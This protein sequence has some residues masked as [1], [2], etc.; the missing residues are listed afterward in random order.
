MNNNITLKS[1][2]DRLIYKPNIQIHALQARAIIAKK[3]MSHV[4]GFPELALTKDLVK[5]IRSFVEEQT[6]SFSFLH[7]F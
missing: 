7:E 4:A 3:F 5:G 2:K 1:N 6:P